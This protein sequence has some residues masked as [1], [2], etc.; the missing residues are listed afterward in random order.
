MKKIIITV[1]IIMISALIT[2]IIISKNRP[3][4]ELYTIGNDAV[5]SVYKVTGLKIHPKVEKSEDGDIKLFIF[6]N[7][8]NVFSNS[9]KYANYLWKNEGYFI[10]TNYNFGK[11][12]DGKIELAK[13][14]SQNDK[15]VR[16][17][18]EQYTNNSFIVILSLI[19][20]NLLI[21]N[22]TNE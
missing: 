6:K 13:N 16:I 12:P 7:V 1:I 10:T 17:N 11:A 21:R 8:D 20:G 18:I 3:Y 14:S 4:S 22:N 2:Y 19:N 15:V 9:T 5:S